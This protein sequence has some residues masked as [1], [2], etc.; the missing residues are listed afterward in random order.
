MADRQHDRRQFLTGMAA[1]AAGVAL[2][3]DREAAAQAARPGTHRGGIPR[4][5]VHHHYQSPGLTKYLAKYSIQVSQ[6]SREPIKRGPWTVSAA[7]E[8]LDQANIELAYTSSATY[9]TRSA[10]LKK[11]GATYHE[12]ATA[13]PLAREE[14]EYGAG[15]VA[16]SKGR[17]RLFA[18]LPFPHVDGSL[19][20]IEYA[21]GTLKASGFCLPT[22]VGITYLGNPV[23]NPV[24]AELNRRNA[25]VYTHPNEADWAI[26]LVPGVTAAQVWYGNDTTVAIVS[27]MRAGVPKNYPNIRWIMSHGG[28]TMPFLIERMVGEPV[29]PKLDGTPKEGEPLYYLRRNFFYDTAQVANGAALPALKKAVGVSQILFGTD[30]PWSTMEDHVEGVVDAR[31][32]TQEE[33]QAVFRDN[34]RRLLPAQSS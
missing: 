15:V 6:Y 30:Y 21:L 27:M 19:K 7:I 24:L 11:H 16:D 8:G 23:Y 34:V 9:F 3:P 14:N 31:T 1:M 29:A 10:E 20:E 13:V 32:F 12:A 4:I 22:S 18:V 17:F 2:T 25:I 28:G 26:D 33:L 5:D